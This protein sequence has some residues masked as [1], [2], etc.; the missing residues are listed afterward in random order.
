MNEESLSHYYG[1]KVRTLF[2]LGGLIMLISF[3]FFSRL[4]NLPIMASLFF[5]ILLFLLSLLTN[6]KQKWIMI[7]DI[8]VSVVAVLSFEYHAVYTYSDITPGDS[9]RAGFFWI[10]QILALIF[11]FAAYL[12]TKSFRGAWLA[13]K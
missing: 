3:P 7:L 1:D 8:L 5:F 10:N 2:M 6:P 11:F 4:L 9:L 12:S 13:E